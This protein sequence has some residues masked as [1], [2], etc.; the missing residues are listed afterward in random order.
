MQSRRGSGS[1]LRRQWWR[2][3]YGGRSDDGVR[4]YRWLSN[5]VGGEI[6]SLAVNSRPSGSTGAKGLSKD[7]HSPLG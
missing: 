2:M 7:G 1:S 5:G 4:R 6:I 3:R